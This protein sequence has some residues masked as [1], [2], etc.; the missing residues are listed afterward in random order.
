MLWD[1]LITL[2]NKPETALDGV[3][4]PD[5][6]K[7]WSQRQ[8]INFDPPFVAWQRQ[9]SGGYISHVMVADDPARDTS[10]TL[11]ALS[12][13][14]IDLM[15]AS[16]MLSVCKSL[17]EDYAFYYGRSQDPPVLAQPTMQLRANFGEKR[18]RPSFQI[19]PEE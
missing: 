10:L 11:R 7:Q 15:P 8:S 12:H 4:L 17:A 3:S 19:A 2:T 6:I 16:A 14:L 5:Y 13:Y 1:D 9:V 18:E